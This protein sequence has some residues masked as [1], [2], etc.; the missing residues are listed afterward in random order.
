MRILSFVS[1]VF[2]S[3][4]P[5]PV[6]VDCQSVKTHVVEEVLE[7]LFE[8]RLVFLDGKE[9]ELYDCDLV[10]KRLGQFYI[11]D[12]LGV[13]DSILEKYQLKAIGEGTRPNTD[14]G[15]TVVEFSVA[16][17]C[18]QKNC[19]M[20]SYAFGSEAAQ[21]YMIRVFRREGSYYL[22]FEHKFVS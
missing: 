1:L 22:V 11:V 20:F 8:A 3:S 4:P 21:G 13:P 2:F 9:Q 7:S 15:D 6:N 14:A 18:E 17:S 10:R 19:I 5:I 12:N 16:K